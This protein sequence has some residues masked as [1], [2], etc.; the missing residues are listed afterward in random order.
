SLVVNCDP[1]TKGCS[2]GPTPTTQPPSISKR[3]LFIGKGGHVLPVGSSIDLEFDL[4][5]PNTTP[6]TG[7]GFTDNL[8]AGLIVSSVGVRGTCG[9]G[10]ITAT[11]G[12]ISLAGAT[13]PPSAFC[14]FT[15]NVTGTAPGLKVNTTSPVAS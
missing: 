13:L 15:V 7:V 2:G 10:S 6:L 1:T 8:P 5:N 4:G 12:T 3:F 9:G 14:V 11:G